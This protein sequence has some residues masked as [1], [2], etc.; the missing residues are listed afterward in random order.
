MFWFGVGGNYPRRVELRRFKEEKKC[1]KRGLWEISP[2]V[3]ASQ[4]SSGEK[5]FSTFRLH[6]FSRIG[7]DN[8][9][10][11]HSE[12]Q[13]QLYNHLCAQSV[14]PVLNP[15]PHPPLRMSEIS[16]MIVDAPMPDVPLAQPAKRQK[17]LPLE[18]V[19]IRDNDWTYFNLQMSFPFPL[20]PPHLLTLRSLSDPP[21]TSFTDILTWRTTLSRAL[22]QF[23]G[24]TGS[25]IQIDILHLSGNEAWLRVPRESAKRFQAAVGGYVGSKD[26]G[27]VGFRTRAAGDFLMGVVS[28][29]AEKGL[30]DE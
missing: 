2:P 20:P 7:Q 12:D 24:I 26:G 4:E 18:E 22:T 15:P 25:A 28:K 13:T 27:S 8:H 11:L 1:G 23:L 10:I 9:V 21:N 6:I 17:R 3:L 14:T 30:W 19:T 16:A 5:R 29:L